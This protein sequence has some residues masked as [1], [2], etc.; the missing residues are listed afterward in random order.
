MK[1]YALT[2]ILSFLSLLTLGQTEDTPT[3]YVGLQG[4]GSTAPYSIRF[5]IQVYDQIY[6]E[7]AIGLLRIERPGDDVATSFDHY[8]IEALYYN[9]LQNVQGGLI[10]GIGASYASNTP[11]LFGR[12]GYMRFQQD[13][14]LFFRASL[15]PAI[16]MNFER[17]YE[18]VRWIPVE[19]TIGFTF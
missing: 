3:G 18:D 4:F 10:Y 19:L 6:L 5:G 9:N 12:F 7:P 14:R 1:K 11:Y 16:S 8:S 15:V 13:G 17:F 2:L